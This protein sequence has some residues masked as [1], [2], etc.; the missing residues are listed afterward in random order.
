MTI[1]DNKLTNDG[2]RSFSQNT[3]ISLHLL[4]LI[5]DNLPQAVFWK[6]QN[7]VFLGCNRVFAK[8]AGFSSP[9]EIVGKTD[10]DMPWKEQAEIY[11]ADDRRVMESNEPRLNYVEPH[12]ARDGSTGWANT[13]KI[14]VQE[15]GKVVAL[16]GLFED[17]TSRKLADEAI[18]ADRQRSQTILEAITVP[19]IITR[20]SDSKVLYANAAL[21][22]IGDISVEEVIGKQAVDY[23][24]EPASRATFLGLLQENGFVNDFETRMLR[25]DG[26][27]YWALLTARNIIYEGESCILTL[28]VDI[29]E[30]KLAE[31]TLTESE[32]RYSAVVNQANDG[33]IIIQDNVCQFVNQILGDMLGYTTEEMLGTPFINYVAPESRPL[34]V[35]R[36]KARLAGEDVPL[37]YEARLLRK[38]GTILD[39]ELS[40]GVIKYHGQAA[41]VGLI[42]DITWRK[43][44]DARLRTMVENA[45]EAI[46]IIDLTTGLFTEPNENAV[47]LYGL[48]RDELAKVGPGDVSP[49]FQPDGRSSTEKA[50]E[51]I[52]SA[53]QGETPV[54]EWIH[55]NARGEE[56]PCEV[57]LVRLPG[58]LPLI[59]SSITD[60]STRKQAEKALHESEDRF[61]RFTE[62]TIESL[63][64]HEQGKII[65]ANPA[66]LTMFN[67]ID[68]SEFV[69]KSLL[70]FLA[71][72]SHELVMKQMQ[73]ETVLP[74][75][76][77]CLHKD[78]STFPAET[79]TRS[80]QIDNRTIRATSVRDI[81][82]R[83]RA[84]EA[85]RAERERSQT[86][87]ESITVPM[88]IT[89]LSDG[90]VLYANQALSQVGNIDLKTLVGNRSVNFFADPLRRNKLV[91]L[92][93]ENGLVNDFETQLVRG[94]G[95]VYWALLAARN[96]KYDNENCILTSYIDIS[97][98]KQVE[99]VLAESE[100]K[101]SAVVNQS[102]N[103]IVIIQDSV[104]QFVNSAL[105]DLI[106]YTTEELLGMPFIECIAP[107]ERKLVADRFRARMAGEDV[108][109][110]Y[111]TRLLRK[112]GTIFDVELSTNL[113]QYHGNSAD[114]ALIRDITER[115]Q[116]EK[117]LRESD[118]RFRRFTDATVEG[119]VFHD[120]GI[121]LDVNPA[122]LE[123]FGLKDDPE[124]IGKNLFE[125]LAP[126][127]HALVM[128]KMQLESVLPYEA[129]GLRKDGSRFPMETSTSVYKMGDR[130]V[131]A[132]SIRDIT[133][134]KQLEQQIQ[135]AFER[136][137]YQV[138]L[139]T[140]VSQS[141]AS[142]S[143]L[144]DLYQRV[145]TQVKE[146]FGYYHAQILRYN[147]EQNAVVL[148][149]GYGPV[150]AKMLAAGHRLT[151]G[152]GLIGTAASTGETVLRP[153]L[154]NDPDWRPNP[155]LPKTKG[156]IAV[157]IKLGDRILGVLDVQSDITSALGSEDQ[158]LLEGLCGQIATAIESTSLRQEMVE[159]L[160]EVNRLYRAMS[161]E[162]WQTYR[163]TA[164][165]STGFMFDQAGMRPVESFGLTDELFSR[166]PLTV[167]GGE[168]IGTLAVADDPQR[169]ISPEDQTFLEQISEQITLS[170][171]SARLFEQTQEAMSE[172][173]RRASEL[174]SV[175][176]VSATTS[177]VLNPDIL[178]QTVV[179]L[180]KER[181][182][183]Y[184]A[185]IYLMDEDWHTLLLAAGAGEVGAKMVAD[186]HTIAMDAERSLVVRAARERQAVII[187]NVRNEPGFL[188]NPLL[189]E[190]CSELAV[191]MV[192]GDALLGVFDVQSANLDNFSLEDA[193]IYTTLAAQVAVALQNARLYEKQ[194][195]TVIQLRELDRLK[196]SFLANMSHEL[197]TPLN[198]I[199]GFSDVM[200]EELD[201]PLTEMMDND[202]RLIQKNGQ[203]LLHLI[204]DV[205]D[206][207]KIEA[208]RMNLHPEQFNVH[209]L[210]EEVVNITSSLANEKA[211]VLR[212]EE[213]SNDEVEIFADRTRILQVMINLV[214]NAIKFTPKGTIT[215]NVV[216]HDENVDISVSDTGIG[217]PKEHLETI[218]Q[219]FAQ[220]DS[221]TTRKTGGTGLG[222]PISR[223]L[224]GMHGGRLWAESSGVEGEGSRVCVELPLKAVIEQAEKMEK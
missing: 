197:R 124:I 223:R 154:E 30:R 82:E 80:Y 190:T 91:E 130:A 121:I 139:S 181:F 65:D 9:D 109:T 76:V 67:L 129:Q 193:S 140:Q 4:P 1:A 105:S 107:D 180:T 89:R 137:G 59:R 174:E 47:K 168:V 87:L 93:Q 2:R 183:L 207:A 178:L 126:E 135:T 158:L 8:D 70:A 21:A 194:A 29:S 212:F 3:Q 88:I 33:V 172:V 123:M 41:D 10:F 209:G 27:P 155:L 208:G 189:P 72:E 221:S 177:T 61:R 153:V 224:I 133:E 175:A 220:V 169:P 119:L 51:K 122:V 69:G 214:N 210:I 204:N 101:Y 13:S 127:S 104:F 62:A 188:P 136:R 42:R 92:L 23:F 16:L 39:A 75:E 162:G 100:A 56:I 18:K 198:S 141:I 34:L 57:R 217:I 218:F 14:P 86:I 200:L 95:S 164:D 46:V 205:L 166:I 26:T 206:M 216:R 167:L 74:Y 111:E 191:P 44:A 11:R 134:R 163:K 94:D 199:L 78:G 151:I 147:P 115:K 185:H 116:T 73:S 149:T 173:A 146:Q 118:E 53:M 79:S 187:G 160:D 195:A 202:L 117:A 38:D 128:Q 98:R 32:A 203:H 156:E 24:V 114:V 159:R 35:S 45:P 68:R 157:P 186:E 120:R 60:I 213:D 110:V 96:I 77:V 36:V 37:V 103:G 152:E 81:S 132:S 150:G 144:E 176:R 7:L 5:M 219:E 85:M 148:V 58:D 142:A 55:R 19:M 71:P 125:F 113:I 22:K 143:S 49:L 83:K 165:F 215:I 12:T 48:S 28:T 99:Q 64:F 161:H 201:G 179:D 40:A 112:D 182:N 138:Q 54:F 171:E 222:L 192:V 66:A 43:L 170:L 52:N 131:R 102:G 97:E 15:N 31:Q 211:L 90:L 25:G 145:V 20:V 196:S 6:D 50:M 184:H 106:G 63:V 108:P 84:E 17:I